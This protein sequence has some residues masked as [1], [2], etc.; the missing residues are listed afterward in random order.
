MATGASRK[1]L[2][3]RG[4]APR[5]NRKARSNG[6]EKVFLFL[7]FSS[8][9]DR[10]PRFFKRLPMKRRPTFFSR[11]PSGKLHLRAGA[12]ADGPGAPS[13]SGWTH[14]NRGRHS[15][16][17]LQNINRTIPQ[18]WQEIFV[19][20]EARD[21]TTGRRF[22]PQSEQDSVHFAFGDIDVYVIV[23]LPDNENAAATSLASIRAAS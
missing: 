19:F 11:F 18:A 23:D 21:G 6:A 20:R 16:L 22:Y 13:G 2:P 10:K 3:M 4:R 7:P 15:G 5:C 17:R 8:I 14:A 9:P 12:S 1:S